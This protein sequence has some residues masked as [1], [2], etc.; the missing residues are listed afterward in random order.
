[1]PASLLIA[2]PDSTTRMRQAADLV[3]DP[4]AGDPATQI[5]AL[6]KGRRGVCDWAAGT[7]P[8]RSAVLRRTALEHRG[9]GAA[10]RVVAAPGFSGDRLF[11]T[12]P[13]AHY[14]LVAGFH[15]DCNRLAKY[16]AYSDSGKPDAALPA[17]S[18][19]SWHRH[20]DLVVT[21]P[22]GPAFGSQSGTD[23]TREGWF[24]NI[25]IIGAAFE[26]GGSD[27]WID[28][29]EVRNNPTPVLISGGNARAGMGGIKVFYAG[30]SAAMR[31]ASS[32]FIASLVEI[33]DAAAT[34]LQIDGADCN[35]A[36]LRIDT[37]GRLAAGDALVLNA[38]RPVLPNVQ[39]ID[40]G[41]NAGSPRMRHGVAVQSA[42]G[43]LVDAIIGPG[44]TGQPYTGNPATL[45]TMASLRVNGRRIVGDQAAPPTI[46]ALEQRVAD[47][48]AFVRTTDL[49]VIERIDAVVR[50]LAEIEPLLANADQALAVA[51]EARSTAATAATTATTASTAIDALDRRFAAIEQHDQAA[52]ATL[53]ALDAAIAKIGG[54][55]PFMRLAMEQARGTIAKSVGA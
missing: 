7:Y 20:G 26:W 41:A 10:S 14:T 33:Q 32:R 28:N 19:D 31:I 50:R 3:I 42:A 34:S 47:L 5:N 23:G 25:L 44:L 45:K 55:A 49:A 48:D 11:G 17:T 2:A 40:R 35:I 51:D 13:A 38:A 16:A 30:A 27:V 43:G 1:M 24:E 4:A 52:T 53:P 9:E 12:E 22:T 39:I 46:D 37:G 8:A 29:L 21:G 36:Q 15:L 54:N 18:P 6:T